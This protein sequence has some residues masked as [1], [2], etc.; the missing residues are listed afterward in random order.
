MLWQCLTTPLMRSYKDS[1]KAL[2]HTCIKIIARYAHP[3]SQSQNFSLV[4]TS[5]LTSLTS[6]S[7]TRLGPLQVHLLLQGKQA[8]RVA[9]PSRTLFFRA[10]AR[11]SSSCRRITNF[12]ATRDA[13]TTKRR[14]TNY[15][16]VIDKLQSLEV[17]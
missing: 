9:G 10:S 4:M 14:T 16:P 11:S 8:T 7:Q 5:K 3:L 2:S 12:K 1:G 6:G 17:S 13:I 15:Q